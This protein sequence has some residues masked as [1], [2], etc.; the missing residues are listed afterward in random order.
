MTFIG[1]HGIEVTGLILVCVFTLLPFMTRFCGD[2]PLLVSVERPTVVWYRFLR[3]S[4]ADPGFLD[5]RGLP[6]I[7][8]K[9]YPK[10]QENQ[11]N[12]TETGRRPLC[13]PSLL[14]PPKLPKRIYMFGEP[15]S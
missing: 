12:W 13:S 4:V 15:T 9:I 11:R 3:H 14:D 7:L 10:Q 8:Q 2:R 5:A 1:L 6:I